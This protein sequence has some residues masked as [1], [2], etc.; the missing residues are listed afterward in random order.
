MKYASTVDEAAGILKVSSPT[1]RRWCIS[2]KLKA[3]KFGDSWM[4]DL[5]PSP[6]KDHPVYRKVK[7][8]SRGVTPVY[9]IVCDEGYRESIVCDG[10]YEWAADWLLEV[11]GRRPYAPRH[12]PQESVHSGT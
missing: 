4:I 11:L 7:D 1:V 2:G 6:S 8:D 9:F 3:V 10:M 12:R 5:N